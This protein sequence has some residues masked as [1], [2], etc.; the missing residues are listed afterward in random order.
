[1]AHAAVALMF[2]LALAARAVWTCGQCGAA[3][4]RPFATVLHKQSTGL[5][6]YA[7]GQRL[8]SAAVPFPRAN[9]A[10]EEAV[11]I[12]TMLV[13]FGCAAAPSESTM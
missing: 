5:A 1:M 3:G 8:D 13:V 6:H 9:T 12:V 2:Y 4:A 11:A 7:P 10:L